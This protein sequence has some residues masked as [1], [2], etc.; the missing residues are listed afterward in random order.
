[1]QIDVIETED[2]AVRAAIQALLADYNQ[3]RLGQSPARHPVAVLLRGADGSLQGGAW[4]SVSFRWLS[5]EIIYL[6]PSHRGKGLG[7]AMLLA[8]EHASRRHGA[9]GV[10]T[11]SF[12][13]PGFFLRHGYTAYARL[14]DYPPGLEDVGL[15]KRFSDEDGQAGEDPGL[16]VLEDADP[17]LREQLGLLQRAHDLTLSPNAVPSPLSV[18]MRGEDGAMLGGMTGHTA[19][20][21]LQVSLLALPAAL[22]GSGAGT[23]ILTLAHEIARG[24]GAIG[25]RLATGGHQARPFY[26][27]LGYTAYGTLPDYQPG[28][29]DRFLMAKRLDR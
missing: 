16:E 23:R 1:M 9:V 27:K 24:R 17:D 18:V 12:Q 7:R 11:G 2:K 6:P 15:Y 26:E 28:G 5:F 29:I 20:D 4:G 19:H 13:A 22:R 8:L 3:D 25:T 14:A 10:R 21:W